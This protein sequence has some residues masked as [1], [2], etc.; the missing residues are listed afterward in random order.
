MA[1][2][3]W[4]RPKV[5]SKNRIKFV[6]FFTLRESRGYRISGVYPPLEDSQGLAV[7]YY[8]FALGGLGY[9][10][11][12]TFATIGFTRY[13]LYLNCAQTKLKEALKKENKA[14]RKGVMKCS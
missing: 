1:T 4:N 12:S 7:I 5:A 2:S 9:T 3:F 8:G 14:F 10:A 13:K 11:S 6:I